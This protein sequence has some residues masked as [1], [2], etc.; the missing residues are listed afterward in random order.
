MCNN[1]TYF[2]I[3]LLCGNG[4]L[5]GQQAHETKFQVLEKLSEKP[6]IYATVILVNANIGVVSDDNGNFR[7][8]AIYRKRNDTLK[9]SSIGYNTLLVPLISQN[10]S[11]MNKIFM[12]IKIEA[13]DEVEVISRKK[14]K[15]IRA[16]RIVKE[17]IDR[18]PENYP[19][20]PFSYIGYYRD[21][22]QVSNN[23]YL[24]DVSIEDNN[25]YINL[26]EG[27]IQVF[28]AGFGTDRLKNDLNQTVLYEFKS[29]SNFHVDSLLT[30]PYDNQNQKYLDGVVITPLGGNELNLLN[31]TDAIRNYNRMSFSF[32]HVFSRDFVLNHTFTLDKIVYFDDQPLYQISFE[33]GSRGG[34]PDYKSRGTISISKE[35][36][37]IYAIDYKLYNVSK[38]ELLYRVNLAYK[39]E[40]GLYYLNYITFNNYFEV[41]AG[42]YFKIEQVDYAHE[43]SSFL[44]YFNEEVDSRS[45]KPIKKKFDFLYNE[46][47]LH[48]IDIILVKP[49][50]V[51]VVIQSSLEIDKAIFNGEVRYEIK[52]LKDI[53]G[54]VLNKQD[55]IRADQF[56][57]IFVQKVFPNAELDS[58]YNFIQKDE[59]LKSSK[60]N[61]FKGKEKYWINSPLK[62][63]K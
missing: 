2:L 53:K 57:E 56:R 16:H 30:I 60:K 1:F 50:I 49:D 45:L 10:D 28:D 11:A 6:V 3:F 43:Y 22:Q 40:N 42:E 38:R 21:Y 15:K 32:A 54:R 12:D 20:Q 46:D 33:S 48:I 58:S 47:S 29:N 8:P 18:I 59:P 14:E 5:L 52:Q 55:L 31:L 44:I 62:S 9:I 34:H 63:S 41:K 23:S 36:F 26:N 27:I 51:R 61:V 39:M 13:L 24:S 19:S 35:N 25:A 37:G 4:L 7:I 17:A